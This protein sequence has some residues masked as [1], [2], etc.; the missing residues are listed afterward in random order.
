MK[1]VWKRYLRWPVPLWRLRGYARLPVAGHDFR[2]DVEDVN[3]WW[4]WRHWKGRWE[5]SVQDFLRGFL[6]PGD[7]FFDVG[8]YMGEYSLLGAVCPFLNP[9]SFALLPAFAHLTLLKPVSESNEGSEPRAVT[10][11]SNMSFCAASDFFRP[12]TL[13]PRFPAPA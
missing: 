3:L 9:A 7:V 5:T 6:Q 11:P 1:H 13:M 4:A 10:S 8:A 2:F 12:E